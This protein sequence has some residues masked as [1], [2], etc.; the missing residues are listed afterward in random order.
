MQKFIL[1]EFMNRQRV[2][3]PNPILDVYKLLEPLVG[4]R[5][6][7]AGGSVSALVNQ[8]KDYQGDYDLFFGSYEDMHHTLGNL[9]ANEATFVAGTGNAV[10][11]KY[12]GHTI[13]C[14]SRD[15]FNSPEDLFNDFDITVCMFALDFEKKP[16]I[17]CGDYAFID[18]FNKQIVLHN[19]R[20]PASTLKRLVKYGA[21]GFNVTT[22]SYIA[23]VKQMDGKGKEV[24]KQLE[25]MRNGETYD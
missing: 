16:N 2:P 7:L 20:Q 4:T 10:T 11:A 19:V 21:R 23:L 17:Y 3:T 13:Q 6:W 22:D 1:D 5:A 25:K 14:I 15:Y 8:Q 18:L 12:K 9:E 24:V